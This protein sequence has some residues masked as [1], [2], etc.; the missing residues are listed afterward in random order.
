MQGLDMLKKYS[1]LHPRFV[2]SREENIHRYR[3][4]ALQVALV[5]FTLCATLAAS[6]CSDDDSQIVPNDITDD[7]SVEYNEAFRIRYEAPSR[8]N[9]PDGRTVY[10]SADL[11]AF[12][13]IVA[14]GRVID[15]Q[16]AVQPLEFTV[17]GA[18]GD[19]CNGTISPG[20]DVT[21]APEATLLTDG[22][23]G[24]SSGDA[25]ENFIVRITNRE[26]DKVWNSKIVI[27]NGRINWL[28]SRRIYVGD[29]IVVSAVYIEAFDLY[30]LA[31]HPFAFVDKDR[32]AGTSGGDYRFG[33]SDYTYA[34]ELYRGSLEDFRDTVRD[35]V[36]GAQFTGEGAL[37][38]DR[39]TEAIEDFIPGTASCFVAPR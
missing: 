18:G 13:D 5:F 12:S 7:T 36:S 35:L 33:C 32:V 9:C 39:K 29:S 23:T 3:S 20:V 11:A 6:G 34:S 2:S 38:S 10:G 28:G 24:G 37:Y 22:N 8:S 1:A 14:Y 17:D 31:G 27:E 26:L 15:I 4:T 19:T 25:S 16:P 30:S 21:I